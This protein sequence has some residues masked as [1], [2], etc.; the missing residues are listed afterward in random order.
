M[1]QKSARTRWPAGITPRI[2]RCRNEHMFPT[3]SG[4]S[5]LPAIFSLRHGRTGWADGELLLDAGE[6]ERRSRHFLG[7]LDRQS[8]WVRL[9]RF[10]GGH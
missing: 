5:K 9:S 10:V 8:W 4:P 7:R 1:T 2:H 6:C 3:L